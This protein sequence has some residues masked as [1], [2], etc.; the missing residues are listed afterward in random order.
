MATAAVSPIVLPLVVMVKWRLRR[1]RSASDRTPHRPIG[2][3]VDG[4]EASFLSR[5]VPHLELLVEGPGSLDH[6]K[7]QDEQQGKN[8]GELQ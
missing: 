7:Q 1:P 6:A 2:S 5:P 4:D 8:D 3:L